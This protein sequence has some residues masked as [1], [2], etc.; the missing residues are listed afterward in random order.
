MKL[1][2]AAHQ[3]YS[4]IPVARDKIPMHE[5]SEKIKLRPVTGQMPHKV[6]KKNASKFLVVTS[7][8]NHFSTKKNL[9]DGG[10]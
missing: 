8:Y 6:V 9:A 5:L 4:T 10:P 1:I 2:F 3:R 7:S